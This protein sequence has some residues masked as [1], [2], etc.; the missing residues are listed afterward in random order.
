VTFEAR[1]A[2][3]VAFLLIW[4][5]I[6]LLPWAAAA[7]LTRGRGAALALPLCLAAACAFGV[8]VPALGAR[9]ATGF[10]VSLGTAFIGSALASVA[11]TIIG[12]WLAPV[13][14]SSAAPGSLPR[15]R[16]DRPPDASL[17]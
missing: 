16:Q 9:D 8:A 5:V 4:C 1:L 2:F 3:I 10:F 14:T 13:R 15:R 12:Q 17:D 7:I 6:G 11:G